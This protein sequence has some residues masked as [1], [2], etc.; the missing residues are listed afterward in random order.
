MRTTFHRTFCGLLAAGLAFAASTVPNAS[1]KLY[2][3]SKNKKNVPVDYVEADSLEKAPELISINGEIYELT[4]ED[5]FDG[6]D[7]NTDYWARCPEMERSDVG[8]FWDDDM[9]SVHDGN[10]W[11]SV[12]IDDDGVPRTGAI[13][14]KGIFEQTYGYFEARLML[15]NTSGYWG[16]FWMMCGDVVK[17]DGWAES[18]AEIDIMETGGYPDSVNHA[19]HWDGYGADLKSLKS[20]AKL[21]DRDSAEL[22]E[23]WH[24]YAFEWTEDE[25]RF[26][27]DGEMTWHTSRPKICKY[28]GYLKLTTEAGKWAGSLVPEELPD[29]FR[30]DWVRV[31][32]KVK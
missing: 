4:M 2:L 19:I 20:D 12:D 24:T 9:T 11:L 31:Y 14:S 3:E 6:N 26:Y 28:P 1:S 18:G 8:G 16:A 5:N 17:V 7:I 27:I 29:A 13:R 15:Q 30:C 21:K 25:Y 10:L 32:Q 22:Y 23:G